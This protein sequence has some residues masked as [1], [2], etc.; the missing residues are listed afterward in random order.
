MVLKYILLLNADL[1][2]P[3]QTLSCCLQHELHF[4]SDPVQLFLG[5]INE[6]EQQQT[7]AHRHKCKMHG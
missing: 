7:A 2:I 4:W 1:Y 6:V 3:P 5:S